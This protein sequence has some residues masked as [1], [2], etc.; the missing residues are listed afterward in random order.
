MDKIGCESMSMELI[1]Q[2]FE[3]SLEIFMDELL[4]IDAAFELY[5]HLTSKKE[6]YLDEMNEAPGFFQI[7]FKSLFNSTIISLAR[8]YEKEKRS[9]RNI[10]FFI[11]F[12]EKHTNI[13]PHDE[14]TLKEFNCPFKV[15][16]NLI[17]S[18]RNMLIEHDETIKKLFIWRDK[19]YAHFD[20][21]Y[22]LNSKRLIEDAGITVEEFRRLISL[23]H[24]I[25][26]D[27][28]IAY[29]GINISLQ[30]TNRFD[31]DSILD[32]LKTHNDS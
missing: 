9:D 28:S 3:N 14:K 16:S 5:V 4:F 15:D 11:S 2:Q 7:V 30:A 24:E 31:I 13:F 10:Y 18:H 23:A 21:K 19:H 26:N 6:E 12:I 20:K 17:S 22:F 8:I 1:K 29:S 27:Y 25:F 32:I